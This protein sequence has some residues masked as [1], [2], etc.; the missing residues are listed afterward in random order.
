MTTRLRLFLLATF[1]VGLISV[2]AA[3]APGGDIFIYPR[4]PVLPLIRFKGYLLNSRV[5]EVPP[6][7]GGSRGHCYPVELVSFDYP[8]RPY[9]QFP[10]GGQLS[11]SVR[12]SLHPAGQGFFTLTDSTYSLG[13]G[14][15]T[16]GDK[17]QVK[18]TYAKGK[19]KL[20]S[21]PL[22]RLPAGWSK[23]ELKWDQTSATLYI[24][25]K[26]VAEVKLAAPFN[27][28]QL[29]FSGWAVDEL[30]LT[31]DG[32]FSLD[33]ESGYAAQI[34]MGSE[35][36]DQVISRV[37]GFDSHV[38]SLDP[39]KRDCPMVQLIN[40]GAEDRAVTL[41]FDVYGEVADQRHN[42]QQKVT[43]PARSESMIPIRFPFDVQTDVYH[44]SIRSAETS[45][46][47]DSSKHFMYV[48]L[49]GEEAGPE[50]FGLHHSEPR[51]LGDWPDALPIHL[52]TRYIRW[53][54]T[55]GPVWAKWWNGKWG[56]DP[57]LPY[58]QWYW[59]P[60]IDIPFYAG[61][62]VYVCV[63][64]T[65]SQPWMRSKEYGKEVPRRPIAEDYTGGVPNYQRYRRFL[66]GVASRYKGKVAFY[67][68]EN[69]P[70]ALGFNHLKPEDYVET[71]KAVYQEVKA[72]DPDV[73]VFGIC[74]TGNFI[75]YMQEV[76]KRG[77]YKYMDGVSWHTYIGFGGS[78]QVMP[79]EVNLT[80]K[81]AAVKKAIAQTG[82]KMPIINSETGLK[83]ANREQI[84]RPMSE[85][86]L[87]A[88]KMTGND[89]WP[90]Y[91]MTER[92]GGACQVENA[93]VNFL[94]GAEYFTVFGWNPTWSDPKC[95][96]GKVWYGW[97]VG[98]NKDGRRTPGHHTLAFGV[99]TAQMEPAIH[100]KGRPIKQDGIQGG[101]F[102]K[103]NG[104]EVAVLWSMGGSRTMSIRSKNP[105]LEYVTLLGRSS[106]LEGQAN[107]LH[108]YNRVGGRALLY[109]RQQSVDKIYALAGAI[110]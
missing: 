50:K 79:H 14:R 55:Q 61:R 5:P 86:R 62:T 2:I 37:F 31:G 23:A 39:T 28:S 20:A 78:T 82:K 87:R 10:S 52:A 9:V 64:G 54:W 67:E 21:V 76:F 98:A 68:I 92:R 18:F 17:L 38:I 40:T 34:K 4:E 104:G 80:G 60:N 101:I 108:S 69:E 26:K 106:I 15:G 22:P 57:D 41:S 30:R 35:A 72:I 83:F 51:T 8:L 95:P 84:D 100:T 46:P 24:K 32:Q 85:E 94:A 88:L 97:F 110:D 45:P 66:R 49:R 99:L 102:P 47:L 56:M 105:T 93:I 89:T 107:V 74:G 73:R 42:W 63:Q 25:G 77:G 43:V 96:P 48:K 70:N 75:G 81:L 27:P 58:Q 71:C 11:L 29:M 12:D 19:E 6:Q 33:W 3:P 91:G 90:Q 36:G 7:E 44:I 1:L 109:S 65:P 53:C 103:T 16:L 59:R 13:F